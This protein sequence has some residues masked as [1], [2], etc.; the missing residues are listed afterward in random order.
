MNVF[1]ILCG[2]KEQMIYIIWNNILLCDD[3]NR[4]VPLSYRKGAIRFYRNN[5]PNQHF[6]HNYILYYQK[7]NTLFFDVSFSRSK[8]FLYLKCT[9][10]KKLPIEKE[11]QT[12]C[13]A[14]FFDLEKHLSIFTNP[15][16]N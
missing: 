10:E 12:L 3:T 2:L 11:L 13:Y 7:I 8:I 1:V 14:V 5:L 9:E 6:C 4:I 15:I 16:C